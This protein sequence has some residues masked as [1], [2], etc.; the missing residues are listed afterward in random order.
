MLPR[1]APVL[2]A[3]VCVALALA[4]PPAFA[5]SSPRRAPAAATYDVSYPQCGGALPTNPT[6]GIVGVNDGIV[7]SANPC[8]AAE[9]TWAA[10]GSTYAPAIY[11]NTG[12]PGPA[13][14]S[15]WPSGAT[16]PRFC[17]GT[18]S[19][20]CSY[21]YGWLAAKDSYADAAKVTPAASTLTWWL[22]VETGNSWETLESGYGQTAPSRAND[23]A[24][25]QGEVDALR[26][27]GVATVGF[28][29]TAYQWQQITGGTGATF[30]TAPAWVAGASSLAAA[31][32]TCTTSSFTGGP[33]ALT[34]YASTGYDA[35]YHCP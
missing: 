12:N 15:H 14:S 28:Y 17:D 9:W 7:L 6:G 21:D 34:Q 23:V 22:D 8:F 26:D 10:Q 19:V 1:R 30:A 3:A 24:A 2:V 16:S 29:S 25:L 33:I 4:T 27:S 11:A 32:S 31:Q 5:K 35:D 13:H 18:N 20:D